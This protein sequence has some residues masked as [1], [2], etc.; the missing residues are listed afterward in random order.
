M[1][2]VE[3]LDFSKYEVLMLG[4]DLVLQ[5]TQDKETLNYLDQVFDLSKDNVLWAL[6]NHD[7]RTHPEWISKATQRPHAFSYHK[8][9]IAFLV[10]DTQE[11]S[12]NTRG[13]QKDLLDKT[14]NTLDSATTHLIVLHHKMVWMMDNGNLQ[15]SVDDISNGQSGDCFYCLM[16]NNFYEEVYPRLVQVQDNGVQVICIAGDIG[17]LKKQ[18]EHKTKEGIYFL[19]SGLFDQGK[20]N[21][22]LLFNHNLSTQELNWNFEPLQNLP[23]K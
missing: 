13:F 11:D 6:G 8:N 19:A 17:A 20:S 10:F 9:N 22:V 21:K 18:F 12:C 15:E 5:S 23:T 2:E 7:Y 16:P 14:L 4:G 1:K 3:E